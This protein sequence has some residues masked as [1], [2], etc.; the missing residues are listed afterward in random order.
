MAVKL[1]FSDIIVSIVL[2]SLLMNIGLL[3]A[4]AATTPTL[5][6]KLSTLISANSGN[7]SIGI[8]VE[9][10]TG[11]NS[12]LL[13]G[14]NQAITFL[15]A[16]TMK[17]F[18]SSIAL[19]N[20]GPEFSV[21]TSVYAT[22]P[23][24]ATGTL[25]GDLVLYGRGDPELSSMDIMTL[26]TKLSALGIKHIT[27]SIIGDSSYFDGPA[28]GPGWDTT[29]SERTAYYS[30]E[31]SALTVNENA[32]Q[33]LVTPASEVG[34]TAVAMTADNLPIINFQNSVLTTSRGTRS[35]I[36][37]IRGATDNTISLSGN[38][39]KGSKSLS[40]VV[41]VHDPALLAAAYLSQSLSTFQITAD[42]GITSMNASDR[43]VNPFDTKSIQPLASIQSQTLAS[44]LVIMD[45]QSDNL[46]SELWLRQV[47]RQLRDSGIYNTPI[48]SAFTK[49][50]MIDNQSVD[51][52]GI[53]Q[54][55]DFAQNSGISENDLTIY[56]GS[57]LSSEDQV[58]PEATAT[59]LS[60]IYNKPYFSILLQSLPDAGIDGTLRN[61]LQSFSKGT[62]IIAKTGT[63]NST[64]ALAGY[65]IKMNNMIAFSIV[66]DRKVSL[67]PPTALVD[68][69]ATIIGKY[70]F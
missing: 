37:A 51:Q 41:A 1:N 65:V 33:I 25:N 34:S 26:A 28:Y 12:S 15:P 8:A 58:A 54:I 68:S 27:G 63:L 19:E 49:I 2:S 56:D 4:H 44:D 61:R 40:Y 17:L 31:I 20:L 45:K 23:I 36:I 46:H 70:G 9:R 22:G 21:D 60:A 16:S 6:K 48:D 35:K 62:I 43:A 24:D 59:L 42:K 39:A 30:A 29:P 52:I 11:T 18:T 53:A 47:G 14:H 3:D 10:L 7:A 57:G 64:N 69:I 38:I 50:A 55:R 13:Y 5:N 66:V 67:K 32:V